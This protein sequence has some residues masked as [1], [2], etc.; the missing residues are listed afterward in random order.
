MEPRMS[1]FLSLIQNCHP[2]LGS[3]PVSPPAQP[4]AVEEGIA[5]QV[6]DDDKGARN[7]T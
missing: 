6:R 7:L 2:E 4:P 5:N 3:G 1:S